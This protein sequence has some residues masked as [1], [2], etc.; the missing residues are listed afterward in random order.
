MI[1]CNF[2]LLPYS[3]HIMYLPAPATLT[4]HIGQ[5]QQFLV[6]QQLS[7]SYLPQIREEIPPHKEHERCQ[8]TLQNEQ[9]Q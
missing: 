6:I 9:E 4:G 2:W 1:P 7:T 8:Q 5:V 3:R